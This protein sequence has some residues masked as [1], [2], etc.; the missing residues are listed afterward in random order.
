M[1][2][3]YGPNRDRYRR[4]DRIE[5]SDGTLVSE[6]VT[7]YAGAVERIWRADG[8]VDTKRYLDGEAIVTTTANA[9]AIT[10][11]ERHLFTDHLGSVDLITDRTG[12]VVQAMS[13]D[14]FGLRRVADD[15]DSSTPAERAG[16][17]TSITTQGFTGH[18]GLDAVGLV[19]MNGRVYDPLIGRFVSAD[20]YIP[21]PHLTQSYNR[22][23][24]T[25]N[26]SLSYIDP[27]GFFFE[28]L[29]RVVITIVVQIVFQ[30]DGWLSNSPN[31]SAL[32]FVPDLGRVLQAFGYGSS[33]SATILRGSAG[34]QPGRLC[35]AASCFDAPAEVQ[36]TLGGTVGTEYAGTPNG[37]ITNAYFAALTGS[38]DSQT[39]A[40]PSRIG[41]PWLIEIP[42][43]TELAVA[44]IPL[45]CATS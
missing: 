36:A 44:F 23:S 42:L 41:Q 14:A 38:P 27:D 17:D 29:L 8:S 31:Q 5:Q 4:I 16:F 21:A 12:A 39:G 37:A 11:T 24:Y 26:N 30:D 34:S 45:G 19:H 6:Q 43:A 22:Y 33:P 2:I 9:G 35:F 3:H 18:E 13:F 10:S 20:P 15:F 40:I 25:L 1:L 7:H 28:T 32:E